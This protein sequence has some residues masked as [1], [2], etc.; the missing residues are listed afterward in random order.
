MKVIFDFHEVME[1]VE[2]RFKELGENPTDAQT[3]VYFQ[4]EK[5]VAKLCSTLDF[6]KCYAIGDKIKV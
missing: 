3:N 5:K 6:D 2:N 1:V 4:P